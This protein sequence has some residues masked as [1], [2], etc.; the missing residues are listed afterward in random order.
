MAE[1][2]GEEY[3]KEELLVMV[4]WEGGIIEAM[5]CGITADQVPTEIRSQW[6]AVQ[7]VLHLIN[8]IDE[9]LYY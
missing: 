5:Q 2:E 8:Q 1:H 4:E 9:Y 6:Q 7:A 3:T